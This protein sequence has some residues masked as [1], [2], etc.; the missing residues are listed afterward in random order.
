MNSDKAYEVMNLLYDQGYDAEVLDDYSGRGMYGKETC[1]V[2]T[3][4]DPFKI[5]RA[6]WDT[7]EDDDKPEDPDPN[8]MRDYT[9]FRFD[10]LAM[11]Y[12]IY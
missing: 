1:A 10:N 6:I 5:A 12:L 7:I 9:S 11:D 3:D 8:W 4:A 2:K